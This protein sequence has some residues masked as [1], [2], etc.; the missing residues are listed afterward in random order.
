MF[1]VF[2][3]YLDDLSRGYGIVMDYYLGYGGT[4]PRSPSVSEPCRECGATVWIS[5]N[6]HA[7]AIKMKV[8]CFTC[9]QMVNVSND[10]EM[11]WKPSSKSDK[12]IDIA[13]LKSTGEKV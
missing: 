3:S 7:D 11:K 13:T 12:V 1:G 9:F 6:Q 5:K 4:E 8:V 10:I 2:C